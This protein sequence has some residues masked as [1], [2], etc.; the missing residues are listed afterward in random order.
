MEDK[1]VIFSETAKVFREERTLHYYKG[2]D[3]IRGFG[4]ANKFNI[5]MQ[6]DRIYSEKATEELRKLLD[7]TT[8]KAKEI[9]AANY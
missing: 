9:I 6:A 8:Q 2:K 4:F 7:E 5:V 1:K 3:G